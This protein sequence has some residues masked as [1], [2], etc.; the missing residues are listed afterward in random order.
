MNTAKKTK[1]T[2]II[3]KTNSPR[4]AKKASR[5]TNL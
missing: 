5:S 2:N 1:T 4:K 3:K